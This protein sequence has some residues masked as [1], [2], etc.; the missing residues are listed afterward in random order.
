[1]TCYGRGILL[2]LSKGVYL[3]VC[4]CG[5]RGVVGWMGAGVGV[6]TF[7]CVVNLSLLFMCVCKENLIANHPVL[8]SPP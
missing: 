2:L 1:M 3:C 4:V 5:V 7:L 8:I 6:F